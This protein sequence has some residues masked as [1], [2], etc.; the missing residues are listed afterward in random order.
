[1]STHVITAKALLVSVVCSRRQSRS[2][3][4]KKSPE[5]VMSPSTVSDNV[6]HKL[7]ARIVT[8]TTC[9]LSM[10]GCVIIIIS[11]ALWPD[12]RSKSRL[13]LAC[14]S[15]GDYMN[16]LGMGVSGLQPSSSDDDGC[17]VQAVLTTYGSLVSFFWTSCI[18]I[19]LY[20]TIV[21][22]DTKKA[23][24]LV[25]V[26]HF[27]S[28]MAPGVLTAV[29]LGRNKLGYSGLGDTAGWC[30]IKGDV[31]KRET[32]LWMIFTGKGWEIMSYIVVVTLYFMIKVRIWQ[33]RRQPSNFVTMSS[34]ESVRSANRK[35][36]FVPI[37]FVL[38]RMWGTIRFFLLI[39]HHQDLAEEE[40]LVLLHGMGD[41]GQG[42]ANFIIFCIFTDRVRRHW[43]NVFSSC[44]HC[45]CSPCCH[46]L[47]THPTG[48]PPNSPII[49]PRSPLLSLKKDDS[50]SYNNSGIQE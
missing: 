25:I 44:L 42:F 41:S 30:W 35:L 6:D 31:T 8:G 13:M 27:V 2:C 33:E 1:M 26:F 29:A 11:Y 38:L 37:A 20:M 12:L 40:P 46:R 49:N 22:S 34:Y 7:E 47:V 16:A 45:Q 36:T 48:P 32:I 9:V 15:V 10:F 17:R 28:W 21:K 3:K 24:K 19:Y 4:T 14:L 18:A 43:I 23:D 5:S 39:S 50:A